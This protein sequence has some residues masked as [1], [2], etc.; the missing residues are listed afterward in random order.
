MRCIR[1]APIFF[2][3]CSLGLGAEFKFEPHTFT[4]PDGYVVQRVAASPL[5]D[6]PITMALDEGGALY[7]ADSSGSNEKP[8]E[9]VKNP[10][11]RIVRLTDR[12][13]DGVFDAQT[14]FADKLA[15]P[16]GTMWLAGSLYVSAPP[17]IWRFTDTD[18][19]GVANKREVWFDGKTLT[20]CANDLHGPYAGPDGFIYWCKGAFAEQKHQ[21]ADGREF[22][23]RAS[24]VFR[25]RPDGSG[26]GVVMT[27]GMDNPVDIAFSASGE[28][29]VSGTFFVHPAGGKRDGIL[30]AVHGGVWGKDHAVLEGHPQTGD[31]MPI[32][33]HVGPAAASG[34]EML[35][36]DS[37]GFRGNLVCCQFNLRKVSRHVLHAD[38][39]TFRTEDSDLLVSD[40]LDFHPT[41]VFED[42]DGS[43]LIA[44]TGGWYRLCCPTSTLAKPGVLGAI[45]RLKKKDAP[46]VLDPTGVRISGWEQFDGPTLAVMLGDVRPFVADRAMAQLAQRPDISAL[47]S[48]LEKGD[49]SARLNAVWTL[50]RIAGEDAR[51]AVRLALND[52]SPEVKILATRTCALWRDPQAV[53]PLIALSREKGVHLRRSAVAALGQLGDRRA[54]LPLQD[55]SSSKGDRFLQHALAFALFEIGDMEGLARSREGPAGEIARTAH[56]MIEKRGPLRSVAPLPMVADPFVAPL[57]PAIV[58]KQRARLDELAQY[59]KS[60]DATRG[61]EIYRSAKGLCTTC[62][63][64]SNTGGT[65]GPDLT[66]IGAIRAERDLLE[67]IVFPA[68]SYVRSYEPLM[69]KTTSGDQLG[70]LKKEGAHEIV[71]SN[72]PASEV[73]ISRKD[74]VSVQPGSMSLMPQGFDGIFTPQELADL[75]A[76]L[77]AAK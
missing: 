70:I 63:A 13:H 47:R 32:M 55:L 7:V 9:Q 36:S 39:A 37:L 25:M 71:L 27:G 77:R 49:S 28:M 19:D 58:T 31:M 20:G 21:L 38:G 72:G 52:R 54:V 62:H 65:L 42:A 60:A 10:T 41:D 68:A 46:E 8:E 64:M 74:I 67:A 11:H 17:K 75:V 35:R 4:V 73:S 44:D 23:T 45:Y 33:T 51:A 57:D 43:L 14:V 30:H 3:H 18:G 34:L 15:F 40:Q 12:D 22:I 29:F 5:V 16:E 76:F 59:L 1:F 24:H 2:A 6:R 69:V 50:A 61:A 53:E 48:V 66:K 56:T 26:F